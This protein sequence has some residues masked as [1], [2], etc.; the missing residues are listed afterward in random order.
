MENR[1]IDRRSFLK[2][3]LIVAA[4]VATPISIFSHPTKEKIHRAKG[5]EVF[6]ITGKVTSKG[7]PVKE[8]VI[9]DGFSCV[10]T[11]YNGKYELLTSKN[12]KYIFLSIPAE[13][14]IPQK[15]DNSSDFYRRID[16]L[17]DGKELNFELEKENQDSKHSFFLLADPQVLDTT[18]LNR[19][20]NETII[21]VQ[22]F[23]SA[24]KIE[25][26]FTVAC[27]DIVFDK[28]ELFEGY[29]ARMSKLK[30][31]SFTVP[32][33]HDIDRTAKT[34]DNATETFGKYFGPNYYSFNKGEF[35]YVVL[36]D[37]FWFA[38]NYMG[39]IDQE[40][41]DWLNNDLSFVPKE[42]TVV[43]FMHIP[44]FNTAYKRSGD[45]QPG[46]RDY[47][48]NREALYAALKG[49]K[50]YIITGHMHESEFLKDEEIE[51]H[52]CGAACGA[53][54]TDNV[55]GDGTPNGYMVYTADGNKLT[56]QYKAT[57]KPFDYQMRIFDERNTDKKRILAN[58]WGANENWIINLYSDGKK[59]GVMKSILD[60]DPFASKTFDGAELPKKH[61]WVDSYNTYHMYEFRTELITMDIEVEAI[62]DQEKVFRGTL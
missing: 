8:A 39:Y 3:S 49:Y 28:H 16:L 47:V 50:S 55:C 2:S 35:H 14:R 34:D 18:D 53:W 56:W 57:G 38:S 52:V 30:I 24:E 41:L 27:G 44:P 6:T 61:K 22:N 40:Q 36:D 45:K 62:T 9:S 17:Q 23:I 42:K 11:D 12:N 31:P 7:N 58:V 26:S 25:N 10:A 5:L 43:L 4:G 51:I 13:Y 15:Q 60:K 20:T 1:M 29:K 54:W 59:L 19:F 37:V 21:D 46:I 33:N 32:G 48:N